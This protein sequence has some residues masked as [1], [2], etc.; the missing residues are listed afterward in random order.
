MLQILKTIYD[1]Q[2]SNRLQ[3]REH[4]RMLTHKRQFYAVNLNE[5]KYPTLTTARKNSSWHISVS[6]SVSV[7]AQ[8]TSQISLL[9]EFI[10][11]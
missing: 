3:A 2:L 6:F 9:I 5:A 11:L 8:C 10:V 4:D 1:T 7:H